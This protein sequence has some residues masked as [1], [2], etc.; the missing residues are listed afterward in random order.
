MTSVF[1]GYLRSFT[2]MGVATVTC[3]AGCTCQASGAAWNGALRCNAR[4]G[5]QQ[6]VGC[7]CQTGGFFHLPTG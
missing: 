1:L 5:V 2:N 3:E 6:Q 7:T 4:G